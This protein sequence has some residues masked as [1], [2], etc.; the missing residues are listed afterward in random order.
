MR[1]AFAATWAASLSTSATGTKRVLVTGTNAKGI[2]G[3]TVLGLVRAYPDL[4]LYLCARD[5]RKAE[6]V[7]DAAQKIGSPQIHV[8]P[9]DL[10]SLEST[11]KCARIV[12]DKLSKDGSNKLNVAIMN[13]GVMACPLMYT[14]EGVEYQY[15]VN[16]LAHALLYLSLQDYVERSLFVSSTAVGIASTRR[17]PPLTAEKLKEH[18]SGYGR[19]KAYGDSKLAMSMFARGIALAGSDTVSLHPGVVDTELQR[20]VVPKALL[21]D[22]GG[23]LGQIFAYMVAKFFRL[24]TPV[25]G[26]ENSLALATA[27]EGSYEKGALYFDTKKK[28]N[29]APKFIAPL[30]YDD[31]QCNA[32][33]NDTIQFLEKFTHDMDGS[34]L[35]LAKEAA[36]SA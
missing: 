5:E 13:A 36:P 22:G 29:V 17:K 7:A 24:K 25:E 20:F 23:P 12:R 32:V 21:R 2:G 26:A 4:E 6:E 34:E 10:S 9:L 28:N 1:S 27:P 16:H 15:G 33:M 35:V 18:L 31:A 14:E 8:V 11:R 30:L 19:W 3:E